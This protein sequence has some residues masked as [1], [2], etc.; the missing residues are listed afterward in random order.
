M[1]APTSGEI[2]AHNENVK[3]DP[4]LVNTAAE[5]DGWLLKVRVSDEKDLGKYPKLTLEL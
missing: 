3:S 2:I 1:Y 4:A 5:G